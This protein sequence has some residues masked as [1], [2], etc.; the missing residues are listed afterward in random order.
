MTLSLVDTTL[1]GLVALR[2]RFG[3]NH[4]T[5]RS[6]EIAESTKSSPKL[7]QRPDM[8]VLFTIGRAVFALIFIFDGAQRLMDIAGTA[9]II[10]SKLTMPPAV[11]GATSYMETALGMSTSQFLAILTGAVEGTAGFLVAFN[12]GV[13]LMAALLILFTA[14][15]IYYVH[16]FWNMTGEARNSNIAPA[17]QSV[18][19]IGA[20]LVFIALGPSLPREHKR[21]I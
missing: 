8:Q 20:L 14:V 13:R 21:D 2:Y 12:V 17:M 1:F 10:N 4:T 18:S 3:E 16:D 15:H 6:R 19:I 7:R 9:A 5:A 11:I